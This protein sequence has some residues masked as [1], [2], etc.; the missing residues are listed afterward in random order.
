M[1]SWHSPNQMLH[2]RHKCRHLWFQNGRHFKHLIVTIFVLYK[3]LNF[4]T[5]TMCIVLTDSLGGNSQTLMIACVS[6]A[7]SNMEETINTLKYADSARRIKNKPIVNRNQTELSRLKQQVSV[8]GF[9]WIIVGFIVIWSSSLSR[10]GLTWMQTWPFGHHCWLL[11]HVKT[12]FLKCWFHLAI[13]HELSGPT[14]QK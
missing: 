13:E 3:A 14:F 1:L 10:L 12:V 4:I 2:N 11:S 7:D 9:V 6:P 5:L 8:A